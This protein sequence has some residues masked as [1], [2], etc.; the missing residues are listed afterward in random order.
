MFSLVDKDILQKEKVDNVSYFDMVTNDEIMEAIEKATFENGKEDLTQDEIDELEDLFEKKMFSSGYRNEASI[1]EYYKLEEARKKYAKDMLVKAIA[2]KDA[3]AKDDTE[4][5]FPTSKIQSKYDA[6]HKDSYFAIVVKYGTVLEVNNALEQLGIKLIAKDVSVTDSYPKWVWIADDSELTAAE[7]IQAMIDLYNTQNSHKVANY[8]T[9]QLSLIEGVHYTIEE[10]KYIFN[11]TVQEDDED[12]LNKLHYTQAELSAINSG[13]LTQVKTN[14]ISYDS[15]TS[16]VDSKQKWFTNTVKALDSGSIQYLAMKFATVTAPTLE[17]VKAE[18]IE[19]LKKEVLTTEFINE[20]MYK[21]RSNYE[22]AIYDQEVNDYYIS[23]SETFKLDFKAS[24]KTSKTAIAEIDGVVYTADQIFEIMNDRYGMNFI[25]NQINYERLLSNTELNKVYDYIN[26]QGS[27]A[28]KVLDKKEWDLLTT[29]VQN[30]KKEFAAGQYAGM[31]WANY[32]KYVYQ[33][34]S[35]HELKLFLLY[36]DLGNDYIEKMYSLKDVE[37]TSPIWDIYVKNMEKMLEDYYN[38]SG[39][40]LLIS[41]NDEKGTPT[42]PSKWTE[43][44]KDLAEEL[45]AQVKYYLQNS[46]GKYS[47]NFEKIVSEFA[48]APRLLVK[49]GMD[50]MPVIEDVKYTLDNIEISKFK[51]AGL[52]VKYED[53]GT[54][55][56]GK[57]V[58]AFSVAMREIWNAANFTD[59]V[60]ETTVI[61]GVDL[62]LGENIVSEFGYHVYVNVKAFDIDKWEDA[63]KDKHILPTL[64]QIQKYINDKADETLTSGMKAAIT[65]YFTP[66]VT[67]LTGDKITSIEL[68]TA[69]K[70]FEINFAIAGFSREDYN[71]F[72]DINI[73]KLFEELVYTAHIPS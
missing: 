27:E 12:T 8:P 4:K 45:D 13:V 52:S 18:I 36:E 65:K 40:H 10:D 63:N 60:D 24:K 19:E 53:L 35:E 42:D 17:S 32:I 7:T 3:A 34:E 28:K 37:N 59:G 15:E 67:E 26:K 68:L 46:P 29:R 25:S 73:E 2:E 11:T 38:V 9:E 51:S 44:Q 21:M 64:E 72:L 71:R 23:Q 55:E 56:N 48:K 58:E 1:K 62:S 30:M 6:L 49:P 70:S 31:G 20:Q 14:M 57:M 47:E 50:P 66:I 43:H 5:Y 41:V 69:Q 33:V 39:Y 22:I 16:V 61:Y 54:F